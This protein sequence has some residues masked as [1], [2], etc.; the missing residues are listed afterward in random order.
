M[1]ARPTPSRAVAIAIVVAVAVA[2]WGGYGQHWSWTGINGKTATLWDWLHLL[3]LPAA[4]GVLPI[5]FSRRSSLQSR[6]KWTAGLLLAAFAVLVIAG[7]SIPWSWTGFTGNKL[8]DWLELLA[9]PLAVSLTPV[10]AELRALWT[11]R[12]TAITFVGLAVF[13]AVVAAGY[14]ANWSWTGFRGNTFWDWLNLL[15]V[16]LLL[17]TLIVP[18]LA[19]RTARA[20]EA[21]ERSEAEARPA[22]DRRA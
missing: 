18:A 15:L 19:S 6:H 3:L 1:N 4:L 11:R 16:P 17:P 13:V 21:A 5:L 9:L 20:M 2:L 7:Y 12:H 10:F 14:M 22:A 8:W